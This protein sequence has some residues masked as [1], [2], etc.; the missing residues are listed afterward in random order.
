MGTH[1]VT[2]VPNSLQVYN[3]YLNFFTELKIYHAFNL[4]IWLTPFKC[5]INQICTAYIFTSQD[6]TTAKKKTKLKYFH[7][8]R[9]PKAENLR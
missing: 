3:I 2:F 9:R 7:D 8:H 5:I 6:N 1:S 4:F